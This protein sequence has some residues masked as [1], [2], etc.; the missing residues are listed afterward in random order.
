MRGVGG[1]GR[2]WVRTGGAQG[3]VWG[4]LRGRA[5]GVAGGCSG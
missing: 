4:D 2:G 5:W 1:G 3:K